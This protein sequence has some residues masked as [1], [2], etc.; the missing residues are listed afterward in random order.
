MVGPDDAA[1]LVSELPTCYK[2]GGKQIDRGFT[3][4]RGRRGDG[5]GLNC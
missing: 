5:N 4:G 3:D 1:Q 2:G